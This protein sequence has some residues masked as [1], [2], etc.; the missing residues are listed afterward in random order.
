MLM[1]LLPPLATTKCAAVQMNVT[2]LSKRPTDIR[3][4]TEIL[5]NR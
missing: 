2:M 5:C 3:T 1:F 4:N